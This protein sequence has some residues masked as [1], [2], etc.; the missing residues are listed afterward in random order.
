MAN[1]GDGLYT[2]QRW[3]FMQELRAAKSQISLRNLLRLM[4]TL[5]LLTSWPLD[6]EA[7][8]LF[9][10]NATVAV[11]GIETNVQR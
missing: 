4:G 6:L 10:D 3:V 11:T 7:A 1:G 8:V 2:R 9:K 5:D